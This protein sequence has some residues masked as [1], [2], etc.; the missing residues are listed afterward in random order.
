LPRRFH[1]TASKFEHR[2]VKG[3]AVI[4]GEFDKARFLDETA[5]FNQMPCSFPS[6]HDPLP[7]IISPLS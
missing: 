2:A 5:Q 1:S 3:G 6:F 4:I 7:R